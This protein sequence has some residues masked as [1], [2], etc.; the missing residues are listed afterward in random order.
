M[1]W[2]AG[3]GTSERGVESSVEK[4]EFS[5]DC[6]QSAMTKPP[7]NLKGALNGNREQTLMGSRQDLEVPC[8]GAGE[9]V[10]K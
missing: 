5:K 3:D 7:T 10:E 8:P 1:H 4:S 6:R 2:I 9:D